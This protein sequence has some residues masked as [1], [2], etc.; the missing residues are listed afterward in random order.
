MF[1]RRVRRLQGA[2]S[3]RGVGT[4]LL[5]VGPDLPYFT[6][7]E[8]MPS[9]RLTMLVVPREGEPKLVIPRLEAPRA[10]ALSLELVPWAE[11]DDPVAVVASML[12]PTGVVAIGDHTWSRFLLE[13]QKFTVN[14]SWVRA[15]ALTSLL[16]VIKDDDEVAALRSAAAQADA[17]VGRIPGEI[18]FAGSREIDVARQVKDLLLEEGHDL[19]EFAIVASGPNGA[20]PHHE[21]ASRVI[22]GGDLVVIDCGGSVAGYKSDTTRTF[23]VGEPTPDQREVHEVVLNANTAGRRAVA[24]G[25]ACS[26]VDRAARTVIEN[27][28]YGEYFIHRT[29]HGIGLEVHE[30]PYLVEGN[31]SPLQTGMAFSVEPGIYLQGRFG[32]RIEDIVVCGEDGADELNNSP[33]TLIEVG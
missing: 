2:M 16:R 17:A 18:R 31:D 11:T 21:A 12:Q 24:A 4:T 23:V 32:V 27:A 15:S 3:E 7:Y 26:E 28:G 22:Q 13:L 5:S 30:E 14:A 1:P 19:A 33:R 10:A 29:G 20:S 9:E 25:V 6:G 8:A